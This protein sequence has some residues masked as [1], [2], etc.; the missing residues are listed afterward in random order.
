MK[1]IDLETFITD[2]LTKDTVDSVCMLL[3]EDKV[4]LDKL[5]HLITEGNS[6][7]Q[8][9]SAW[10]FE[11]VYAMKPSVI[12]PYLDTILKIF[13]SLPNNGVR[14]HLSKILFLINVSD[15]VDGTFINTCFEWLRAEEVP[16]AVK[17]YC[18]DILYQVVE[19]Y[20]ELREELKI[21]LQTY[22]PHNTAGFKCRAKKTLAKL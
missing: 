18:M 9:R 7:I 15:K 22:L 19:R 11:H 4:L 8:W 10:V 12:A 5:F 21:T 1:T 2:E 16:V 3:K 20:P 6:K 14:R 13:P 17:V